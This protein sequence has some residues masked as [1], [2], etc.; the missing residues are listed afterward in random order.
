[1]KNRAIAVMIAAQYNT[2]S[3]YVTV[4]CLACVNDV[5]EYEVTIRKIDKE[6]GFL[7]ITHTLKVKVSCIDN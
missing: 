6:S 3:A 4:E 2:S 1:M 5:Y 7:I